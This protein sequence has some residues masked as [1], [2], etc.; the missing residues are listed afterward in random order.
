MQNI[1]CPPPSHHRPDDRVVEVFLHAH[2][3]GRFS[4]NLDWLKQS[5]RNVEVIAIAE[6]GTRLAVEHTRVF[7]FEGHMQQEAVL[8]PIA[9]RLEA[10]RLP[11]L[12]GKWVQIH[13]RT[14]F[15]GRKLRKRYALVQDEIVKFLE[16]KL[17]TIAPDYQHVTTFDIPIPLP[18]GR[19]PTITCDVEVW[20][21]MDVKKPILVSGVLPHDQ[22]LEAQVTHA[23]E[24]KLQK[25]VD[26]EADMRFLMIDLPTI[27]HSEI[28]VARIIRD[29]QGEFPLLNK[30]DQVVFAKTF[31]FDSEGCVF[32][33]AWNPKT[34]GLSDQLQASVALGA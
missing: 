5:E 34:Q 25:L 31:A 29:A 19:R 10:L 21:D 24:S 16:P 33:R 7:A 28:A 8:R 2:E 30:I 14:N 3:Q 15:I 23:L 22:K 17:P 26:S 20:G 18:D 1:I 13:F 11:G 32:F 27:S 4:N 9:E 6:D 12:S